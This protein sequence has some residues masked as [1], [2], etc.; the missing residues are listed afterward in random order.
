MFSH[1]SQVD[2]L[3]DLVAELEKEKKKMLKKIA[4]R[5]KQLKLNKEQLIQNK[6][7]IDRLQGRLDK[8]QLRI[9]FCL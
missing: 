3:Q 5:D 6:K 1:R 4:D 9:I 8:V 7:Q 2:E